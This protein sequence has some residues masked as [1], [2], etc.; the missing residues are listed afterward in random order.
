VSGICV[1]RTDWT[2]EAEYVFFKC[3]PYAWHTHADNLNLLYSAAGK[4]WLVD[5]GTYTYNGPWEWRTHFRGTSAHN[6]VL[7]DGYGQALAHRAFRWLR[8]PKQ[9]LDRHHTGERVGYVAGTTTG[10]R[11]LR[12]PVRHTRSVLIVHGTYIVVL[13]E[14]EARGRHNYQLLFQIAPRH[15][16]VIAAQGLV[17]TNDPTG[18]NFL[19]RTIGSGET[20]PRV[21]LGETEPIQGWH[22]REY[23]HKEP[24]P[25]V[26]CSAEAA[27]TMTF[28]TV[29]CVVPGPAD[30]AVL[31]LS[32]D[33]WADWSGSRAARVLGPG[34]DD[35]IYL[36]DPRMPC[37]SVE[38]QPSIERA[39]RKIPIF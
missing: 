18:P 7:V 28:L 8:Q 30:A 24:A 36:P 23:G 35:R 16:V 3:S 20:E 4:D 11:H 5:R 37:D 17:R 29:L 19:L 9:V 1:W 2:R 22:S 14:L 34:F 21:A 6:A 25:T 38:A 26:V 12:S 32:V 15:E 33:D 13:D 27:E 39:G 10:R 31:E